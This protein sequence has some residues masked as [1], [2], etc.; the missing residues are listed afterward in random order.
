MVHPPAGP[1]PPPPMGPPVPGRPVPVPRKSKTGLILGLV[2]GGLAVLLLVCGGGGYLIWKNFLDD[3]PKGAE[4]DGEYGVVE[5]LCGAFDQ[6]GFADYTG[7]EPQVLKDEYKPAYDQESADSDPETSYCSLGTPDTTEDTARKP[8]TVI[9]AWFA[10]DGA[11]SAD[12]DDLKTSM[13]DSDDNEAAQPVELAEV[14]DA[15]SVV[16]NANGEPLYV[17]VAATD[18]NISISA[19]MDVFDGDV[20][21]AVKVATAVVTEAMDKSRR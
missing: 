5:E 21:G 7:G 10:T 3:S 13:A 1:T 4:I 8:L 2:G 17:T 19:S 16:A 6:G 9:S 18:A 20:E 15:Y 11:A 12:F 14:D